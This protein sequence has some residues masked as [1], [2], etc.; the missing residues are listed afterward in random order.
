MRIL[1]PALVLLLAAGAAAQASK[2]A[3]SA[4]Q[5]RSTAGQIS[6]APV[7]DQAEIDALKA[8]LLRMNS[9]LN[10]MRTNLGYVA[11]TT[12]PLRHQF[13]LELDMWQMLLSQMERRVQRLEA[14]SKH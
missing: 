10:Q 1:V 12:Q 6:S 13:E 4:K 14:Q 5:A 11:T 7:V 8:D 2:P 9:I 3:S